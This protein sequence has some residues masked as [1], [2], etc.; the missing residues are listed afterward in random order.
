[1]A[2][3]EAEGCNEFMFGD[4]YTEPMNT[5]TQMECGCCGQ[6]YNGHV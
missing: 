2:K 4:Y 6:G 1:M 5:K 3:M